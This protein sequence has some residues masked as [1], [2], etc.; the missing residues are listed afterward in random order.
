MTRKARYSIAAQ[1]AAD[2]GDW[3]SAEN[4]YR[5]VLRIDA[6]NIDAL[7]GLADSLY[8]QGRLIEAESLFRDAVKADPKNLHLRLALARYYMRLEYDA[9]ALDVLSYVLAE[10]KN[11]I[12]ALLLIV[13]TLRHIGRIDES[14]ARAKQILKRFGHQPEFY[15]YLSGILR[16]CLEFDDLAKLRDA[17]GKDFAAAERRLGKRVMVN[18]LAD[19]GDDQGKQRL[20]SLGRWSAERLR[21]ALPVVKKQDAIY[22]VGF[23]CQELRIHPVAQYFKTVISAAESGFMPNLEIYVY[24]TGDERE[25]DPVFQK[26]RNFAASRYRHVKNLSVDFTIETIRADGVDV[27]FDLG[28]QSPRAATALFENRIAPVQILWLGWGHTSGLAGMDYLLVDR[29][30]KPSDTRYVHEKLAIIDAPYMA[31][32]Q[33][34]TIPSAT[35]A[36]FMRQRRVTFGQP[37][38]FDKWTPDMIDRDAEILRRVPESRMLVFRP[39]AGSHAIAKNIQLHFERRGIDPRRIDIRPNAADSYADCLADIDIMLDPI[40]VSGGATAM[41]ALMHGVPLF[42]V[43]GTQLFQRFSYSFLMHA[44]LGEFCAADTPALIVLAA[45]LAND[46]KRLMHWR[47]GGVRQAV[48]SSALCDLKNY[49]AAW[50]RF[51]PDILSRAGRK[52]AV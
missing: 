42:T 21:P 46:E 43:S 51:I 40:E 52:T 6:K 8:F 39:D 1:T 16:Q 41:D 4:F 32:D 14:H 2:R 27:L 7:N 45:G 17:A 25:S 50:S 15:F 13:E 36:P 23:V 19:A 10:D 22:R 35:A 9:A 26:I 34:P 11:H 20:W 31:I 5:R 18:L 28:G 12:P 24:N 44:G 37:N 48:E 29:Y 30:C 38:R 47:S 33:L 3:P 49:G